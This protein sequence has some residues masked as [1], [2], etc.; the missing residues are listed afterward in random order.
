MLLVLLVLALLVLSVI[1][2]SLVSLTILITSICLIV[3]RERAL[4][5]VDVLVDSALVSARVGMID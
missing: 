1:S 3:S 4:Y 5:A 2:V